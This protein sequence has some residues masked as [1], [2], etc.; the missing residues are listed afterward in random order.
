M[1]GIEDDDK[2]GKWKELKGQQFG[3]LTVL[4]DFRKEYAK[5]KYVHYCHCICDCENKTE[6]DV[7]AC[8]LLAG[9]ISDCGCMRSEHGRK[10][11]THHG[12]KFTRIYDIWQDIKGRCN[13]PST[14]GYK[15]Y[16]GRGITYD[17]R[18]EKFE[19]FYED[20]GKS[21]EEHVREFG[22]KDTS[23]D[24]INVD[25]NYCKDNCKWSTIE[26]QANNKTSTKFITYNNETHS[27]M[28]WSKIVDIP[29]KTI[30]SRLIKGWSEEDALYTPVRGSMKFAYNGEEHT[31]T[32]WAKI[33]G[34][35]RDAI[36]SRLTELH[37]SVEDALTIPVKE[38]N[39]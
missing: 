15:N 33:T 25:G 29:Y 2:I 37:W 16:G 19:P 28:H 11:S 34:I 21:Y 9:S 38:R 18:W 23:I 4:Y 32:E 24:R 35:S 6:K 22:E 26:E 30:S 27:L 39:K 14:V 36:D 1:G 10:A 8:Y 17:S 3:K 5:G 7:R 20:M 31:I 13:R 12:M